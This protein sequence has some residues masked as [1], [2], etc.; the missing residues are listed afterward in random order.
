MLSG[1]TKAA[2]QEFTAS[3]EL[4]GQHL[5][6]VNACRHDFTIRQSTWPQ[7][8]RFSPKQHWPV[9]TGPKG[10]L[11]LLQTQG[12]S[13][14]WHCDNI[15]AIRSGGKLGSLVAVLSHS[16]TLLHTHIYS[17]AQGCTAALRWT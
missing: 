4:G 8:R 17:W 7:A 10:P 11:L 6:S 1:S 13:A 14:L 2:K 3:A 5:I 12:G 15:H 16:V 9:Q